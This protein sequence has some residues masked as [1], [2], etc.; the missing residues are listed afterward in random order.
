MRSSPRGLGRAGDRDWLTSR[1]RLGSVGTERL[2]LKGEHR[3][4]RV[5]EP[6]RELGE[7]AERVGQAHLAKL[8]IVAHRPLDEIGQGGP[9]ELGQMLAR[10][11]GD[12]IGGGV[13]GTPVDRLH[14]S[15]TA[16]LP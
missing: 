7:P 5:R 14:P 15:T 8:G 6:G 10:E 12:E 11:K 13:D 4:R 3:A 2:I 1:E 9:F 16:E